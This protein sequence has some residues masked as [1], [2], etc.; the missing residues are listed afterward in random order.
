MGVLLDAA[1]AQKALQQQ[2]TVGAGF[3][4]FYSSSSAMLCHG[5]P[6]YPFLPA[7]LALEFLILIGYALQFLINM[8]S[9]LFLHY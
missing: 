9:C 1:A 7:L 4:F 8:T 3:F 2:Y 5:F 6:L